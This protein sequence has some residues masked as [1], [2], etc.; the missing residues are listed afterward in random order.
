M[1]AG[2]AF[3][4]R[5]EERLVSIGKRRLA[6]DCTREH[7]PAPTVVLIGG[8]GRTAHFKQW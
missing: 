1:S 3:P 2:K 4:G 8:Q 5:A 6:I 7:S